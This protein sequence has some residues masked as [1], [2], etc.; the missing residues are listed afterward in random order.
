MWLFTFKVLLLLKDRCLRRGAFSKVWNGKK[1]V[2]RDSFVLFE[3]LLQG[4]M[5][6]KIFCARLHLL[7]IRQPIEEFSALI[8][9]L[10]MAAVEEDTSGSTPIL[11]SW[12]FWLRDVSMILVWKGLTKHRH[13]CALGG[14]CLLTSS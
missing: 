5:L 9:V 10:I 14:T 7:L 6:H 1:T 11:K 4:I 12:H 8:F 2:L 13:L 3:L